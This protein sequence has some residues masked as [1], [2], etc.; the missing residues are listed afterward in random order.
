MY[1]DMFLARQELTRTLIYADSQTRFVK[2]RKLM[3]IKALEHLG[4]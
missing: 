4:V 1:A 3:W 2:V